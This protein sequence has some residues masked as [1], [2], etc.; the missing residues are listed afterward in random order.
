MKILILEDDKQLCA[1]VVSYLSQELF[2]DYAHNVQDLK[3]RGGIPLV[4]C[5]HNFN[6]FEDN[7]IDVDYYIGQKFS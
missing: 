7:D 6:F 2:V 3:E 4:S 1:L 5:L